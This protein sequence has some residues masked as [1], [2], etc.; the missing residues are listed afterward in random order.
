[1]RV[2]SA[3]KHL[4]L[5]KRHCWL[6]IIPFLRSYEYSVLIGALYYALENNPT[7]AIDN[8]NGLS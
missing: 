1:M 7:Q 8:Q 2:L 5:N 4:A 6:Y 3:K